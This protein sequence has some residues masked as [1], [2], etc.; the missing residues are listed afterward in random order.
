[1]RSFTPYFNSSKHEYRYHD[2]RE[3]IGVKHKSDSLNFYSTKEINQMKKH[4]EKKE[5]PK[6]EKAFS[7]HQGKEHGSKGRVA[8]AFLKKSK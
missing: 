8:S 5:E 1:M 3:K 4:S 6:K 7:K 2:R